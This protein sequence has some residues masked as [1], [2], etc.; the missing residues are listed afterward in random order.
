[1]KSVYD[2]YYQTEHLFGDPLPELMSCLASIQNK[3]NLLDLGCGQ[4]RDAIP[5]AKMGF[6]VTAVDTSALGINQMID[7]AKSQHTEVE[8]IV[9]DIYTYSDYGGFDVILLDSMFHFGK[10]DKLK[11]QQLITKIVE[12]CHAGCLIV[13]AI[14]DSGKKADILTQTL[15][16]TNQ[17]QFLENISAIYKFKD[18]ETGHSSASNYCIIVGEKVQIVPKYT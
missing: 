12:S 13:V 6:Q 3:G 16:D 15:K 4:G 5:L 10:N 14:Q 17:I 2:D 7:A 18:G 9:Q 11:E 1:M 8:G